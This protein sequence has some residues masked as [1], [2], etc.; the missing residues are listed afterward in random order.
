MSIL[1][2]NQLSVQCMIGIM[3]STIRQVSLLNGVAQLLYTC[4]DGQV[5]RWCGTQAS[6]DNAQSI[7][8]NAVNK[9]SMLTTTPN[10]CAVLSNRVDQGKSRDA[11][12]LGTCTRSRS[13]QVA[14]TTQRGW[15]V[16]AQS[17]KVVTES[18]R[19]IQLYHKIRWD[20]TGWQ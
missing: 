20:W 8:E 9:A 2:P 10:W 18:E 7:L 3:N 19:P 16:L 14:S 15:R 17:L 4:D 5:L 1:L 6:C 11:H 13:P 12:C